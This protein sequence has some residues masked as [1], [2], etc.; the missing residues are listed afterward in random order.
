MGP[1]V[2]KD[3]IMAV[4]KVNCLFTASPSWLA[5]E[6][7][8]IDPRVKTTHAFSWLLVSLLVGKNWL[9]SWVADLLVWLFVAL[10]SSCPVGR[11]VDI[12]IISLCNLSFAGTLLLCCPRIQLPLKSGFC[13]N[14]ILLRDFND[15]CLSLL[16]YSNLTFSVSLKNN[17][18]YLYFIFILF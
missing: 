4:F 13:W 17:E 9:F 11:L 16:T 1:R 5:S 15:C 10:L 8:G 3:P 7:A 12:W 6:K 14:E 2:W 18:Y